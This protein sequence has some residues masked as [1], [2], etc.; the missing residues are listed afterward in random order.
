[1]HGIYAHYLAPLEDIERWTTFYFWQKKTDKEILRLLLK[2]H[3]DT[4]RYGLGYTKFRT[5]RKS[6]GLLGTRQQAHTVQDIAADMTDLRKLYPNAGI[7][8]M[9]L[10]MFTRKKKKVAR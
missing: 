4:E 6:F 9:R 3:I 5:L 1:M 7:R 8:D 2:Y 10:H